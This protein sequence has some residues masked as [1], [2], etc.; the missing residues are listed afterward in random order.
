MSLYKTFKPTERLDVQFPTEAFNILL[1]LLGAIVTDSGGLLSHSA[2]VA[3][4][5]GIPGVV[6]TR[7]ATH[8]IAD[9]ARVRVEGAAGEVTV[10]G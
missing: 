1:P 8:R 9:G 10:L 6:G 2:I 4:E 5:Y 7:E 3:R